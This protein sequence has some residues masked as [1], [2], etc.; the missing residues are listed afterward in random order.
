MT[1]VQFGLNGIA[2]HEPVRA[3]P[4]AL[5]GRELICLVTTPDKMVMEAAP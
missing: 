3:S 1:P 2:T 4:P 5:F